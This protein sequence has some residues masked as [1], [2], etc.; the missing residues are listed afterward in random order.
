MFLIVELLLKV[1]GFVAYSGTI[2]CEAI[3]FNRV[4]AC[5][6]AVVLLFVELLLKVEP[7]LM[8]LLLL[9][10]WVQKQKKEQ[11]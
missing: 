9:V 6:E 8:K 5:S 10:Q 7:L 4:I 1:G 11:K 3:S 2:T